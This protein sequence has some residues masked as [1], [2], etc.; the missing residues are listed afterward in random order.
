METKPLAILAIA[1]NTLLTAS[2]QVLY[3]LGAE[4]LMLSFMG[5]LTN[6]YLIGGLVVYAVSAVIMIICLKYGE[7]SVLYPVIALSFIWVNI[8]SAKILHEPIVMLKWA[9]ICF[10][11]LG[12]SCIGFGS[13][14]KKE[15]AAV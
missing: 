7:L 5:L 14:T 6:Y 9:G 2:G 4:N 3:K 12:V 8:M 1:F 10:I 15:V 11:I 13:R